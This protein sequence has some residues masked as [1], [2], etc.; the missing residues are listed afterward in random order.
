MSNAMKPSLTVRQRERGAS[1]LEVLIAMLVVAFG[2]LGYIA[3][4]GKSVAATMEGAQRTQALMLVNDLAQRMELNRWNADA[5]V[6][7]DIGVT[8]PGDCTTAGWTQA[9]RDLCEWSLNIRGAAETVGTSQV[10]AMLAARGCVSKLNSLST[11]GM[12]YYQI[13]LA[14]QGLSASAPPVAVCGKDAY[15]SE[16]TRRVVT[17]VV[18]VAQLQEA[19]P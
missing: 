11:P 14:W 17:A 19:T 7:N 13:T 9:Q 10:G 15:A 3:L 18:Q 2:L 16:D 4:Q 8:A 12:D 6:A 1:L 5:Y